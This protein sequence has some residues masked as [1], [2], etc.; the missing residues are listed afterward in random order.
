MINILHFLQ[1]KITL[2]VRRR[3]LLTHILV[4]Q[5]QEADHK[6]ASVTH[7]E[8]RSENTNFVLVS[9]GT[10]QDRHINGRGQWESDA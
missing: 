9:L 5:G 1:L 4:Q 7:P 6:D 2:L 3:T 10:N 8:E